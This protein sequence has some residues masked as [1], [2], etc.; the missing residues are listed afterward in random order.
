MGFG[1]T[2]TSVKQTRSNSKAKQPRQGFNSGDKTGQKTSR[3]DMPV[4]YC[5]KGLHTKKERLSKSIPRRFCGNPIE[6]VYADKLIKYGKK[7]IY[8]KIKQKDDQ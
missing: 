5:R 7:S 8:Q 3:T 4:A 2:K 6:M 1:L